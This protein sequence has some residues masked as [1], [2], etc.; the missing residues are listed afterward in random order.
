[1]TDYTLDPTL[2]R[3]RA[4]GQS[5]A[6]A[7]DAGVDSGCDEYLGRMHNIC[8]D[9]CHSHVARCLSD[10]EYM[11]VTNWSMVGVGALVI[12]NGKWVSPYHALCVWAPFLLIMTAI[13]CYALLR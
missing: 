10:M 4:P 5:A 7:W 1:M 3:K 12:L 9:N 13:L 6:A 11:G 8:L 2:A